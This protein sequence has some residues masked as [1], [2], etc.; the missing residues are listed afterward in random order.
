[1]Q[2]AELVGRKRTPVFFSRNCVI[3]ITSLRTRS[4][5]PK[6]EKYDGSNTRGENC[7]KNL[8]VSVYTKSDLVVRHIPTGKN[9]TE[10][11]I[12]CTAAEAIEIELDYKFYSDAFEKEMGRL[13]NM[14]IQKN[15][16][17][18]PSEKEETSESS[19]DKEITE[20][21]ILLYRS[22]KKQTRVL[23]IED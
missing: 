13:Y 23:Q 16:M 10:V 4:N 2:I 6:K 17:F 15:S 20:E 9:R 18:P 22:I 11:G 14:F 19:S 21:D 12:E 5:L 7:S 1:L 8:C 3:N